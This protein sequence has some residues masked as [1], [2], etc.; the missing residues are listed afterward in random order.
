VAQAGVKNRVVEAS[1]VDEA[2]K[3]APEA[4]TSIPVAFWV[5]A[6]AGT[7]ALASFGTFAFLGQQE[8]S[9]L[10]SDCAPRCTP[11]DS[12]SVATKFLIA[13][14]S[15]G[16]AIA[17]YAGAAYVYFARPGQDSSSARERASRR[18]STRIGI[19]PL[20]HGSLATF[21]ASF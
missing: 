15:L 7:V 1:F 17:A 6:G 19:A 2:V 11:S 12:D 14:I 3:P 9:E 4:S 10:E 21:E 18:R 8:Y 20:S 13:D 16:V 5:L